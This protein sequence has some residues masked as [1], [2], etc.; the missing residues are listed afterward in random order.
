M[1][2]QIESRASRVWLGS[3]GPEHPALRGRLFTR[4]PQ[5]GVTQRVLAVTFQLHAASPGT[6]SRNRILAV[7]SGLMLYAESIRLQPRG[8]RTLALASGSGG[9]PSRRNIWTIAAW[10]AWR[11]RSII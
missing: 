1:D 3:P 2:Q 11:W 8:L 7:L 10:L 9:A 4:A 6:G 5:A